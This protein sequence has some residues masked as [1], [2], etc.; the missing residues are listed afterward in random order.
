[1]VENSVLRH[2]CR[3][4]LQQQDNQLAQHHLPVS[5]SSWALKQTSKKM[6]IKMKSEL[7]FLNEEKYWEK[8][9]EKEKVKKKKK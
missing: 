5:H 9:E 7:L 3:G 6:K 8:N 2:N 4:R 1:M